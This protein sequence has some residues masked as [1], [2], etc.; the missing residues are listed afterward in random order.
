MLVP[1]PGA[2]L[3]T[4]Q[5]YS[6]A[7]MA[8]IPALVGAFA[9]N[10]GWN[11]DTTVANAPK[12]KHPTLSGAKQVAF[13]FVQAHPSNS[14]D[15]QSYYDRLLI[16]FVDTTVGT[17]PTAAV[18]APRFYNAATP[19]IPTTPAPTQLHMFGGTSPDYWLAGVIAFGFNLYRHF[20]FGYPEK[21]GNYGNGEIITGSRASSFQSTYSSGAKY[22]YNNADRLWYP[23]SAMN[24]R[25]TYTSGASAN[26]GVYIT[27]NNI[28]NRWNRFFINSRS[29]T[30]RGNSV[31]ACVTTLLNS[32]S[33]GTVFGGA[34]DAVNSGYLYSGDNSLMGGALLVPIN[35]YICN[36]IS[37]N[38]VIHPIGRPNGVR[39]VN[40]RSLNPEQ[41]VQLGSDQWKVF[42]IFCRNIADS[43]LHGPSDTTQ[44]QWGVDENS[45]IIGQAYK[46]T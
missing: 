18:D 9:S 13:S 14:I 23:F 29:L 44:P 19:T 31:S 21:I 3:V 16:S 5:A 10:L 26:G 1:C 8:D 28:A 35:L 36:T 34:M 27:H 17:E 7:S 37:G 30:S 42:P 39:L 33:A 15:V 46:M 25:Y 43:Y 12:I 38:K 2:F 32:L 11:V 20:Y 6:V 40:V 24:G 22:H 41:I 45:F 4:Y